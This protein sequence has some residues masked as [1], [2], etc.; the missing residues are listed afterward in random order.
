MKKVK[1]H[2]RYKYSKSENRKKKG[3]KVRL[4]PT[5]EQ[6]NY[7]SQCVGCRR[8]VYNYCVGYV[9]KLMNEKREYVSRLYEN[10]LCYGESFPQGFT[11]SKK[12]EYID[13][14]IDATL[15]NNIINDIKKPIDENTPSE[16]DFINQIHS[17]YSH[18]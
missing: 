6:K 15:F 7:I 17:E 5:A 8:F 1:R 10:Y 14:N 18:Q 4:R 12:D 3:I 16:F 9:Q 11:F 2:K 13:V